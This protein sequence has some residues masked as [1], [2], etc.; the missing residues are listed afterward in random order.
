[1]ADAARVTPGQAGT[2]K[3]TGLLDGA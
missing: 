3:V 2:G 1:V